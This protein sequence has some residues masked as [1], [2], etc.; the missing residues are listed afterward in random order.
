M[1]DGLFVMG[2]DEVSVEVAAEAA[3]SST[4]TL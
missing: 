2:M 1:V 3:R 4:S